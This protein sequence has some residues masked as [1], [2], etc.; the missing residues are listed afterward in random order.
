MSKRQF[1]EITIGAAVLG[2]ASGYVFDLTPLGR[3]LD[4]VSDAL[5]WEALPWAL[6][7]LL[8]VAIGIGVYK[9]RRGGDDGNA[10]VP[11]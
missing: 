1:I 10:H 3:W 4:E 11:E 5:W 6:L 9:E 7:V 2:Y 8:W